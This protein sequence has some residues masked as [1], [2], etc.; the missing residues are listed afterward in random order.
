M[1]RKLILG[2]VLLV[3]AVSVGCGLF[4]KVRPADELFR[5][6]AG[7]KGQPP[8]DN[9]IDVNGVKYHYLHVPGP[10]TK[11]LL[12]HGFGSSTYTWEGVLPWLSREGFDVWAVDM[13]GFGWSDKPKDAAYDPVSLMEGVNSFME[14][15]GLKSAVVIGN[16]LGGEV[17]LLLSARHPDKVEKMALVDARVYLK[18]RPLIVTLAAMPGARVIGKLIFG[19]GM[20]RSNIRAV[21]YNDSLI[22]QERIDSYFA[23]LRTEGALDA[24]TAIARSVGKKPSEEVQTMPPKVKVPTLI[25]W[26]ADDGWIPVEHALRLKREIPGSKMVLLEQCGH[27]PQ[28]EK[29]LETARVLAD[30]TAGRDFKETPLLGR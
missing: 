26:G 15:V 18:K 29:P 22:T 19:E 16:S 14:A 12:I 17:T 1:K 11:V 10:G 13:Y 24:T 23:R 28:E 27:V 30:F 8:P 3:V 21:F 25:L 9:F 4:V 20:V 6:A 7:I 2:V 5:P